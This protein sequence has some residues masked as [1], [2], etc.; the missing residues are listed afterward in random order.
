MRFEWDFKKAAA[1]F[2]KHRLSFDEAMTAFDDPMA[3]IAPDP[4]Y[5]FAELR[6]WRIGETDSEKI[7]VVVY[8]KRKAG[9]VIRII[10]ARPA[11]RNERKNYE[12]FK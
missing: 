5:S 9:Q 7:V 2:K 6:E 11:S 8:T 3:L 12:K 4:K 1:N 10:S